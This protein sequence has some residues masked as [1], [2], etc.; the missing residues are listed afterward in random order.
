MAQVLFASDATPSLP[1]LD[2]NFNELYSLRLLVTDAGY[3]ATTPRLKFGSGHGAIFPSNT[4][5]DYAAVSTLIS[6]VDAV[7][8]GGVISADSGG[9][10]LK[11]TVADDAHY[12]RIQIS[13]GIT[14][15]TAV[16]GAA[17]AT[18]TASSNKRMQITSAGD[19]IKTLRT[20]AP[21]LAANQEMVMTLTSNTNLRI[22]V[23]GS[24]GTT[25]V[26]NITL[27]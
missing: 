27:A 12:M 21:T 18:H 11:K 5:Y 1:D 9:G 15:H 14:F 3:S 10:T 26:A 19:V 6:S 13:D 25:R 20:S 4:G 7:F 2:A 24:D 8:G 16:T 22:S 17:G 23:R